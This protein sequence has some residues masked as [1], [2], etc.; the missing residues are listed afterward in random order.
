MTNGFQR[1]RDHIRANTDTPAETG[2]L[3]ERLMKACLRTDLLHKG[4]I[5]QVSPTRRKTPRD[6]TESAR[7]IGIS[8][9]NGRTETV[10]NQYPKLWVV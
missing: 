6:T 4:I 10:F 1:A 7:P 5:Q 3:F 8:P 2:P 9:T